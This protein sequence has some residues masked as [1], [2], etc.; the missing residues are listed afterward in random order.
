M[1]SSAQTAFTQPA[2][3]TKSNASNPALWNFIRRPIPP[4]PKLDGSRPNCPRP[5]WSLILLEVFGIRKKT[6]ER[7]LNRPF[8]GCLS[9]G[10][11]DFLR[12]PKEGPEA[13]GSPAGLEI[14]Q[15]PG[16]RPV[17]EVRHPDVAGGSQGDAVGNK[18][19]IRTGGTVPRGQ[20]AA[21]IAV[22]LHLAV[23]KPVRRI[24]IAAPVHGQ[25]EKV[26]PADGGDGG[27][28]GGSAPQVAIGPDDLVARVGDVNIA[29][30]RRD[31]A[32]L[33]ERGI[34]AVVAAPLGEGVPVQVEFLYFVISRIRHIDVP[35]AVDGDALGG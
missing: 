16:R 12:P 32:G 6:L 1:S 10:F 4:F 9:S 22:N 5:C 20:E 33:V 18:E 13:E 21:R 23:G 15:G 26:R 28:G 29:P 35:R 25:A 3:R 24:N 27:E 17:L 31:G 2:M 34:S 8:E 7:R 14:R 30:R 19:G 11:S